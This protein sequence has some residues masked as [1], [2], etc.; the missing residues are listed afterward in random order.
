[1]S[2]LFAPLPNKRY[3]II[4]TDPP[5]DYGSTMFR[6]KNGKG[7]SSGCVNDHYPTIPL[8]DLKKLPVQDITDKKGC[9]LYMWVTNPHLQQGLELMRHWGFEYKQIPFIWN[10]CRHT[11]TNYSITFCE[12]VILGKKGGIPKPRGK[13]HHQ[14]ISQP[15]TIHSKKPLIVSYHIEQ[16][17][18]QASRIELFARNRNPGWDSWGNQLEDHIPP[19]DLTRFTKNK[20]SGEGGMEFQGKQY[21]TQQT[22]YRTQEGLHNV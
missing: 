7:L 17:Y 14:Y 22:G 2:S 9:L 10:K 13:M 5:W 11:P 15:R 20:T 1:M 8:D 12:I 6:K 4:L 19:Y 3:Q 16:M 18:P 21:H